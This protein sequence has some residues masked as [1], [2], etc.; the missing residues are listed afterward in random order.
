[1]LDLVQA[2]KKRI[3]LATQKDVIH[4][5]FIE[6]SL[7][8]LGVLKGQPFADQLRQT[9][10]GGKKLVSFFRYPV[11]DLLKVMEAAVEDA[12]DGAAILDEFGANSVRIFF[13]SP[14]GKTM[15]L[16]ASSSPHRL[17]A[18]AP[19]G[20]KASASFGERSYQKETETSGVM[21]TKGD[22]LG[23]SWQV[24]VFKQA[25]GAACAV[26]AK[27]EVLTVDEDGLNYSVRVSW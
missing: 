7:T 15:L 21:E 24:G 26:Q 23:P 17:L 27:V 3:P 19:A 1:M 5:M 11:A 9:L 10:M 4:G 13:D 8:L 2:L 20:F 18:S 25:L 14:V 22:L 6:N 16:L 12:P